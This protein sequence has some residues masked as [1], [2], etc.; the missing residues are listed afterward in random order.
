MTFTVTE[1]LNELATQTIH[2]QVQKNREDFI[3]AIRDMDED[4]HSRGTYFVPAFDTIDT[5]DYASFVF[6]GHVPGCMMCVNGVGIIGLGVL[7]RHHDLYRELRDVADALGV[8]PQF[9]DRIDS[10]NFDERMSF[11]DMAEWIEGR[12]IGYTNWETATQ[13]PA[14]TFD[15]SRLD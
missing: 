2:P 6:R 15:A 10:V 11:D 7:T 1:S 12:F 14:F 8:D 5:I 3:A 9:T 13:E 4:R